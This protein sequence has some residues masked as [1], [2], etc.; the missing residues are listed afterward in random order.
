MV[1]IKHWAVLKRTY[2]ANY[3][4]SFNRY[5]WKE[6]KKPED[7]D[8]RNSWPDWLTQEGGAEYEGQPAARGREGL[9]GMGGSSPAG[10]AAPGAVPCCLANP[11]SSAREEGITV[12]HCHWGRRWATCFCISII[13]IISADAPA[14]PGKKAK[15]NHIL[16]YAIRLAWVVFVSQSY[17]S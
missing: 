13:I 17:G 9:K 10:L 5:S 11:A 7:K 14:S 8:E 3:F 12:A 15:E 1:Y 2:F 16:K 6:K 4:V